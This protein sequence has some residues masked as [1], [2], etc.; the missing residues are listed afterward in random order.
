MGAQR[1]LVEVDLHLARRPAVRE[2]NLGARDGRQLWPNEVLREI[3]KLDLGKSVAGQG[4]LDDRNARGVVDENDR[5]RG[6]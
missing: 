2:R 6:S 4:Q 5:R 1:I 3:E